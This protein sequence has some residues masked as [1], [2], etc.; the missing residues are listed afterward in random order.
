[1]KFEEASRKETA[2][3]DRLPA[4]WE[5]KVHN[6]LPYPIKHDGKVSS[7]SFK[8]LDEAEDI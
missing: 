8:H 4:S 7:E 5:K 3:L 6:H 2:F 1:V